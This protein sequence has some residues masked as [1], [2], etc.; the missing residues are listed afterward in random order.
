[1]DPDGSSGR[2]GTPSVHD[3][4]PKVQDDEIGAG[5][6]MQ[7]IQRLASVLGQ[8]DEVPFLLENLGDGAPD[9]S[10]A[11]APPRET[12]RCETAL[13][14]RSDASRRER[15]RPSSSPAVAVT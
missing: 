12:T 4:H 1:P 6:R 9:A 14:T 10:V 15:T 8:R 5:G 7:L 11:K 13:P 3:R 2:P